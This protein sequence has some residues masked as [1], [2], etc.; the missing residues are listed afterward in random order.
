[1]SNQRKKQHAPGYKTNKPRPGRVRRSSQT[2]QTMAFQARGPVRDGVIVH[3]Q[4]KDKAFNLRTTVEV[5]DRAQ[6]VFEELGLTLSGAVNLLM[7]R[8]LSTRRLPFIPEPL[9]DAED[10]PSLAGGGGATTIR[11]RVDE[12]L[13]HQATELLH[14]MGFNPTVLINAFLR[15]VAVQRDIPFDYRTPNE[16]TQRAMAEL[17]HGQGETFYSVDA[18]FSDVED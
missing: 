11:I 1:M 18:L 8:L 6:A 2:G 14:A 3:A 10:S 15:T 9:T 17:D 13:K 5:R 7:A 16:E 12:T 4:T